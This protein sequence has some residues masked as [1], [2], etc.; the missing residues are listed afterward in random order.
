M[1]AKSQLPAKVKKLPPKARIAI[2]TTIVVG[3]LVTAGIAIYYLVY[4]VKPSPQAA[5]PYNPFAQQVEELNQQPI[6]E[7]P[8]SRA[9]Y[10]AQ[11]G[12]NYEQLGKYDRALDAYLQAQHVIDDNKLASQIVY[13]EAIADVYQEKGDQIH[14]YEYL[15]RYKS[16]L[17]DYLKAHPGDAPTEAAIQ[18]ID[19]RLRGQ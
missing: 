3:G 7:D 8:I 11:I 18:H 1:G 17:Q 10:F 4:V 14:S 16:Y 13:Y 6:P 2:I 12:Q 15:Q 5:E 19:E 9:I